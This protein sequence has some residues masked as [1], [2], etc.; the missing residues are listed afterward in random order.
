MGGGRTIALR[1]HLPTLFTTCS[2]GIGLLSVG[3]LPDVLSTGSDLDP[4]RRYHRATD[5]STERGS[6]HVGDAV[7]V[8]HWHRARP[9]PLNGE[10]YSWGSSTTANSMLAEFQTLLIWMVPLVSLQLSWA[11]GVSA[12]HGGL[13]GAVPVG[14]PFQLPPLNYGEEAPRVSHLTNSVSSLLAS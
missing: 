6:S 9:R 7:G 13:Q 11:G 12:L 8:V 14:W 10:L 1:S 5:T 4:S 3:P 2:R